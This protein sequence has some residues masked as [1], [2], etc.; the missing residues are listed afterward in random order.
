MKKNVNSKYLPC[1]NSSIAPI[2]K[3]RSASQRGET[4]ILKQKPG[5]CGWGKLRKHSECSYFFFAE[6][7]Q[8][9]TDGKI[10][11]SLVTVFKATA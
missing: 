3:I 7:D 10:M 8:L 1:N 6:A 5:K 11:Q 4:V 2:S 9:C